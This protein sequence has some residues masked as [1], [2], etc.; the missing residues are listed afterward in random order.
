M[1]ILFGLHLKQSGYSGLQGKLT[2]FFPRETNYDGGEYN[3]Y[4][5]LI[6][7]NLEVV[8]IF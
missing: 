2:S 1:T 5:F 8:F 3:A 4:N 7:L 6:Q